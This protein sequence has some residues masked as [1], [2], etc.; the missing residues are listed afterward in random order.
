MF[1]HHYSNSRFTL[2]TLVILCLFA[3][4]KEPQTQTAITK[5]AYSIENEEVFIPV[6]KWLVTN[7]LCK[8]TL[9]QNTLEAVILTDLPHPL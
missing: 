2:F 1:Y 5:M 6:G 8:Q 9:N 4:S 3:C 7:D